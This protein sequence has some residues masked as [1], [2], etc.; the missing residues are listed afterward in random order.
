MPEAPSVD[1]LL[2]VGGLGFIVTI[3]TEVIM[4]AWQ[5][6]DE[7]K[8][9]FGPIIAIGVALVFAVLA[10][11]STHVDVFQAVLVAIV[12]GATS[13]GIYDTVKGLYGQR[14]G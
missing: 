5:P 13:M 7:V 6:T 11:I 14:P 1:G 10:A 2:T 3:I 9:R 4:R 12:T 8:G